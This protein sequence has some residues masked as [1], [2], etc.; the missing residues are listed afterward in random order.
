MLGSMAR[1]RFVGIVIAVSAFACAMSV[2]E[3]GCSGN[4]SPPSGSPDAATD[5]SADVKTITDSAFYDDTG[6]DDAGTS[7]DADAGPPF[8]CTQDAAAGDVPPNDLRCTGLYANWDSKTIATTALEYKPAYVLW[9]DGAGKR[10][11]ISLPAGK[12]IDTTDMDA[13]IFP[14]GTKFWKEFAFSGTRV[15]TRYFEKIGDNSWIWTTYVWSTDQ[16]SA[17]TNDVGVGADAG[18]DASYDGYEIPDHDKCNKCH[19][20][21]SDSILGFEAVLLGAPGATGVTLN[22]LKTNGLITVNPPQT[23]VTIPNEL[24][25]KDAKALGWL[26][27][28]CGISCH[29]DRGDCQLQ[30][31]RMKI[32]YK[33]LVFADGGTSLVTDLDTYTSNYKVAPAGMYPG[34]NVIEPGAPM[35]STLYLLPNNRDAIT[36]KTNQMPYIDTHKVDTTDVADLNA[37]I[38]AL[39]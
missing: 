21:A 14:I 18:G 28:N 8:D 2:A 19:Q 25:G 4:D 34:T 13:W 10:R 27:A 3:T 12:K 23:T 6:I 31:P 5:A 1:A 15:E 30:K 24:T 16:K 38:T 29:N 17:V 37:W 39:P 22:D 36:P 35:S 26:H 32:F 7:A 9:S 11:W 20:G 33:Q